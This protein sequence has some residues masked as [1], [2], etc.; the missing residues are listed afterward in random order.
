MEAI[1]DR[2]PELI[3]VDL[4]EVLVEDLL[5]KTRQLEAARVRLTEGNEPEGGDDRKQSG[6]YGEAGD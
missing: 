3:R 5:L 1:F 6:H 2:S 4:E